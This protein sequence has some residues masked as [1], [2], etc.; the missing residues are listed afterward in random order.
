MLPNIYPVNEIF[1][2]IQGEGFNLG[3]QVVFIRLSGCNL[4][5]SWCD[6]DHLKHK[7]M[8][9][10]DICTQVD[11]YNCSNVLITGGEPC[12]YNLNSLTLE[13]KK[14][15]YW[16]GLETN[17]TLPIKG[18]FDYISVSPKNDTE[19]CNF[20]VNEVRIAVGT[21]TTNQQV[22]DMVE[23]IT[24]ENYYLSPIEQAGVFNYLGVIKLIGEL[25]KCQTK[26]FRLSIQMHKLA[27]IK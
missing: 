12:L 11:K 25:N 2:S 22:I 16:I 27:G 5:C 18:L 13:L 20:S 3:K 14:R 7:I 17:G 24:A 4:K 8:I 21:E 19:L 9:V 15:G 26:S 23:Q 6:T 1:Q 10:S